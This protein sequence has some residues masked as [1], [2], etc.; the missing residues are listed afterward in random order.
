MDERE[1]LI[2]T[3]DEQIAILN[4][5]LDLLAHQVADLRDACAH[6]VLIRSD[7]LLQARAL[8]AKPP[9]PV[10][11][12]VVEVSFDGGILYVADPASISVKT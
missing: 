12:K 7:A 2:A 11:N 9:A 3:A 5:A 8:I 10:A 6:W 1:S 4:K